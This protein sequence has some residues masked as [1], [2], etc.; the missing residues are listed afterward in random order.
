MAAKK[1]VEETEDGEDKKV[2]SSI[3]IATNLFKAGK[4]NRDHFNYEE[5][6]YYK[7]PSSSMTLNSMTGG[8]IAPG[9]HRFVGLAAG[10]KTSA[11]LDYMNNFLRTP[12]PTKRERK[13]VYFKSEGRLSENIQKR[14]GITFV[15]DPSEWIDGTCLVVESNIYEF[16]FDFK[17]AIIF[18]DGVELFMI[19]DSADGLIK[20]DDSVKSSNESTTVGGGSLITSV[21]L[22][23]V[24]LAMTKRGHIDI[25]ISQIR[26][27]VSINPYDPIVKKQAGNAAGGRALEHQ[28]DL[29]LE[30][31]PRFAKE[32][33]FGEKGKPV[34]HFC[35]IRIVKTDTER[36][37]ELSYPVKYFQTGGKSVW[38]AYEVADLL[39]AWE[40]IVKK[41]SWFVL[42]ETLSK[43]LL[44]QTEEPFPDKIQGID[45]IRNWIEEHPHTQD[46]FAK[47]LQLMISQ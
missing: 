12:S 9:A 10:G 39:V 1:K 30:F 5:D 2:L 45:N 19:T 8:G 47:K 25:Y 44:D 35:K 17:R 29:V 26:D 38:V 4:K 18:A 24:G 40:L 41:G 31:L 22:K 16:V 23:K 43:E 37:E 28:A 3:D 15:K 34:G 11:A 32:I 21:F 6:Y 27:K 14:S 42:D 46:F 33:I 20:R 36:Y 13:G 7:V